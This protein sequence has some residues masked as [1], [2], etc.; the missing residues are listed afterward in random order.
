MGSLSGELGVGAL[1]DLTTR[2]PKMPL[3]AD[4]VASGNH[5]KRI[6]YYPHSR[7]SIMIIEIKLCRP[8]TLK[9]HND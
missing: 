1:C 4:L 3:F 2:K 6:L 7:S 5:F 9:R 8:S